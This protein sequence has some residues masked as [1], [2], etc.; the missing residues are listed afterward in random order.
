MPCPAGRR[1]FQDDPVLRL[2]MVEII[3]VSPDR[4]REHGRHFQI[5]YI[6]NLYLED[7]TILHMPSHSARELCESD[8]SR[9]ADFVAIN[10]REKLRCDMSEKRLIDVCDQEHITACF[11]LEKK[12]MRNDSAKVRKR[13]TSYHDVVPTK[14]YKTHVEWKSRLAGRDYLSF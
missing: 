3:H 7:L 5:C 6:S 10:D 9:G 13:D 4:Q 1:S 8:S 12:E 14:R 2:V 11:D